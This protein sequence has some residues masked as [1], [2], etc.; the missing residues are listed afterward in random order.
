ML[1]LTSKEAPHPI[2]GI[3]NIM[4]LWFCYCVF[5]IIFSYIVQL[6]SLTHCMCSNDSTVRLQYK[7]IVIYTWCARYGGKVPK[8][9]FVISSQNFLFTLLINNFLLRRKTTCT[10]KNEN[11]SKKK[12]TTY[13][14]WCRHSN[15]VSFLIYFTF[16]V[17]KY[18][19]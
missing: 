13:R 9:R 19:F 7:Y 1:Y 14:E 6:Q 5:S 8:K 15:D 18:Y 3:Q 10:H 12:C 4:N 11:Y 17:T 2:R 16:Y